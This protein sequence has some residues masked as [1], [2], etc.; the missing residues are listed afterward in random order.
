MDK[1]AIAKV[2]IANTDNY[3]VH[4][5]VD[6]VQRYLDELYDE[7]CIMENIESTEKSH[8]CEICEDMICENEDME[9]CPVLVASHEI[10]LS[11]EECEDIL[12]YYKRDMPWAE[13]SNLY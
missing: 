9:E 8:K 1:L 2:F 13:V 3:I 6:E 7:Y 12:D 11:E 10:N 4:G 5:K